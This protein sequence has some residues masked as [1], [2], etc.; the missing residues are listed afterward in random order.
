MNQQI[1]LF[2]PEFKPKKDVLKAVLMG[3]VLGIVAVGMVLM[4]AYGLLQSWQLGQTLEQSR[5]ELN[6]QTSQLSQL[7][8]NLATRSGNE[9]LSLRLAEA[10]QRL[11][12]SRL[13]SEF[14][15]QTQLGNV[16]GFSEYFK[17]LSRATIDGMY[18]TD[19]LITQGGNNIEIKGMSQ[20]ASAL[21]RFVGN[22]ELGKSPLKNSNFNNV[23]SSRSSSANNAYEFVLSAAND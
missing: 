6:E 22:I 1:N 7:R 20:N 21:P 16:Q 23:F 17:D 15:S 5:V 12:S 14:L 2:L 10:E 18:I 4:S 13:V 11:D 3:Q 19:F 8:D 9:G